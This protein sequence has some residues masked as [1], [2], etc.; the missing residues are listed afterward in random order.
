MFDVR[1][2]AALGHTSCGRFV[3]PWSP[4]W[5]WRWVRA[6]PYPGFGPVVEAADDAVGDT[7]EDIAKDVE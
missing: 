6:V 4:A 1:R 5:Y 3:A 2:P 7:V